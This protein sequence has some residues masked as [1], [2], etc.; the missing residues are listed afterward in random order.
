MPSRAEHFRSKNKH[1]QRE[2][3]YVKPVAQDNDSWITAAL[4]TCRQ[5]QIEDGR[6]LPYFFAVAQDVGHEEAVRR[7]RLLSRKSVL[8]MCTER[9]SLGKFVRY[10]WVMEDTDLPVKG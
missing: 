10:Y 3:T 8:K 6:I 9:D 2:V 7:L 4:T 1:A 5:L